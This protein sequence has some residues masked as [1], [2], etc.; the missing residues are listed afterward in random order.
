MHFDR[1]CWF[2]EIRNYGA[3]DNESAGRML[4]QHART[5]RF[6]FQH[7][8]NWAWWEVPVVQTLEKSRPGDLNQSHPWLH[9][10][11][12]AVWATWDSNSRN[13]KSGIMK[14]SAGISY[15]LIVTR[16]PYVGPKTSISQYSLA[17]PTITCSFSN[18]SKSQFLVNAM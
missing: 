2:T 5:S 3:G 1:S 14:A 17:V 4:A 8:I 11:F 16:V 9:S 7:H 12:Q 15:F 6:D 18:Y 10:K 13:N